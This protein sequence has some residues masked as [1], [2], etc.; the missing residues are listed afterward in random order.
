VTFRKSSSCGIISCT[1][2]WI[3]GTWTRAVWQIV[4]NNS[5][6][7]AVFISYPEDG[8]AGSPL[9]HP[10]ILALIHQTIRPH[11]PGGCKLRFVQHRWYTIKPA[12]VQLGTDMLLHTDRQL[13]LY[14]YW[15]VNDQFFEMLSNLWRVFIYCYQTPNSGIICTCLLSIFTSLLCSSE[16]TKILL[17]CHMISRKCSTDG[18][19]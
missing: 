5:E 16:L 15:A 14:W 19:T 18:S 2:L 12:F 10:N 11:I 13:F 3:S 6:E 1:G 7:P 9:P 4:I 8:A 17:H